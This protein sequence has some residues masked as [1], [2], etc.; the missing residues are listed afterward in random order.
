VA[1][2]LT[3]T[4]S[5]VVST[6]MT[7]GM[8]AVDLIPSTV[9][10]LA[11]SQLAIEIPQM[12]DPTTTAEQFLLEVFAVDGP[13]AALIQSGGTLDATKSY[14][15]YAT[16]NISVGLKPYDPVAQRW[17]RFRHDGHDLF[18]ETSPDGVAYTTFAVANDLTG[19][20]RVT[21]VMQ[22]FGQ[23]NATGSPSTAITRLNRGP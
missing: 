3:V 1:A 18:W 15:G 22:T 14:D 11:S 13:A 20:D 23:A 12:V 9:Y 5:S 4:D 2:T 6:L 19:L 8:G 17:W 21:L 16:T 7:T 10:A